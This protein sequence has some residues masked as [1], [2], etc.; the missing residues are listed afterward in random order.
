MNP[1]PNFHAME[2]IKDAYKSSWES[3]V[4]P[5]KINYHLNDIGPP[6][7]EIKGTNIIREDFEVK[8]YYSHKICASFFYTE[9]YQN[10]AKGGQSIFDRFTNS[11]TGGGRRSDTDKFGKKFLY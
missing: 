11:F 6:I 1:L 7:H 4:K 8:N 5:K 3:L 2:S 9:K 10:R